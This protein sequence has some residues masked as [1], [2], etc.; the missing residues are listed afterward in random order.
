MS[1]HI[2]MSVSGK[3]LYGVATELKVC[4]VV[5]S[6]NDSDEP[7]SEHATLAEAEQAAE[8]FRDM[9]DTADQPIPDNISVKQ[10]VQFPNGSRIIANLEPG[11]S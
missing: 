1:E 7:I 10:L 8:D 5:M 4:F 11:L 6:P 2:E 3:P 9:Y